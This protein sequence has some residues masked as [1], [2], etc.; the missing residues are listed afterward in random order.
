MP[1][2]DE[3]WQAEC[4]L[5]TMINYQ[6]IMKDSKRLKAAMAMKK[7]KLDALA[8]AGSNVKSEKGGK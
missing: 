1:K 3:K 8:A 5:E 2:V 7:E 6:K 4:D